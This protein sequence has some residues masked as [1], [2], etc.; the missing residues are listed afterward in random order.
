MHYAE[1]YFHYFEYC[2]DPVVNND[3]IVI[4]QVICKMILYVKTHEIQFLWAIKLSHWCGRLTDGKVLDPRPYIS[5]EAIHCK[6]LII[7][8]VIEVTTL[9]RQ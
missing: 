6:P 9:F 8:F 7:T 4:V 3:S 5:V 2:C 1:N